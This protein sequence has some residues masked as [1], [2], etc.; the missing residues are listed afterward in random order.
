M[1]TSGSLTTNAYGEGRYYTLSWTATQNVSKNT[2]TINWSLSCAGGLSWYAERTV[3]VVIDGTTVYSKTDRVVRYAGTIATGTKTIT[4]NSDGS[5]SFSAS[6]QAAV[7]GSSINCSGSKSFTLT[8]IPRA[9][10]V[11]VPTFNLG[12]AGTISISR[13]SSSFTHTLQYTFGT[14][15]GTIATK[16]TSTSVSWTPPL[17]LANAIPSAASGWGSITCITYNGSTQIGTSSTRFTANVPSSVKP[18]LGTLSVA[19]DNSSNSTVNSWGIYLQGV[20]KAKLTCSASGSY[21]S[22]VNSFKITGGYSATVSGSSLNYTGGTLTSS[23]SKTFTV[24]AVDSRGVGSATKNVSVSVKAYSAPTISTFT[25]QRS[26]S[27]S[28]KVVVKA[29]WSHTSVTNSAGSSVNNAT[30]TLYYKASSASSWSSM[31]FTQKNT[32]V[33]LSPTFSESV[34]YNFRFVV[35][36]TVGNSIE[37]TANISTMDVFLDFHAGGNGLGIGTIIESIPSGYSGLTKIHPDWDFQAF[38]KSFKNTPIYS[39]ATT[40]STSRPVYLSNGTITA[41]SGTVGSGTKPVYMSG[42]TMTASSSTVGN[43]NTPVYMNNGT[44]T[45]CTAKVA[46]YHSY[47][48]YTTIMGSGTWTWNVKENFVTPN[49]SAGLYLV[50]YSAS[51]NGNESSVGLATIRFIRGSE[52]DEPFGQRGRQTI[53]V[54][55]GVTSTFN[56]SVLLNKT[57]SGT[58]FYGQPQVW[59]TQQFYITSASVSIV[60]LGANWSSI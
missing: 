5:K 26:S 9:S 25:A 8:Q 46:Y 39:S 21:G 19:V 24:Q 37:K 12:S 53:P 59:C 35:K 33:T 52:S 3:N 16:T 41:C 38:G 60:R 27:N 28:T 43:A 50:N 29:N 34:S 54:R 13:A 20:S 14:Y 23:G 18:T 56:V 2:S 1:A 17:N 32:S 4:H 10:S 30:A 45:A 31:S 58:T 15:T 36:D 47:N 55:S 7:Y 11:S 44:L 57:D 40:G 22:T 48:L 6:V 51:V 49:L 42:G